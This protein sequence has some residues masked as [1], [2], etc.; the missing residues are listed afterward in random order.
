[1]LGAALMAACAKPDAP[2]ADPA[3]PAAP[4]VNLADVAGT[5]TLQTM[6]EGSDSVIVTGSMVASADPAAWTMTL[7]GRP[8][9]ALRVSTSADSVITEAGPY[10]S[11]LRPGVQVT[12]RTATRLEGGMMVGTTVATY[13]AGPDSVVVLRFRGTRNP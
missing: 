6:R 12:T 2:P 8:P 10:E 5:W 4:T 13:S 7:P 11:V 9:M 3:P 1:V